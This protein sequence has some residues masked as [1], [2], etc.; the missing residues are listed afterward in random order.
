MQVISKAPEDELGIPLP[1]IPSEDFPYL[2]IGSEELSKHHQFFLEGTKRF[3]T[4][5]SQA[6]RLSRILRTE[7]AVHNTGP[8]TFHSF[9]NRSAGSP[10]ESGQYHSSILGI[11]GYLPDQGVDLWNRWAEIRPLEDWEEEILRTTDPIESKRYRNLIFDVEIMPIFFEKI[12]KGQKLDSVD[13]ELIEDFTATCQLGRV[14]DIGHQIL[15]QLIDQSVQSLK[16]PYCNAYEAGR[17]HPLAPPTPGEVVRG[18]IGEDERAERI[19]ESFH[20]RLMSRALQTE[21]E[22]VPL[23]A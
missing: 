21:V 20:K 8:R 22:I 9:F 11:S 4:L 15:G 19:V 3:T 2:K 7:V 14:R 5:G 6:M 10:S 16:A 13:A 17:L 1:I 18:I 12:V 23:A